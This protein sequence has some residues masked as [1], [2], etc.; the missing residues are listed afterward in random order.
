MVIVNH[1][2]AILSEANS[3]NILKQNLSSIIELEQITNEV[4]FDLLIIKEFELPQK[5]AGVGLARKI[6]MDEA[7]R[8]FSTIHKNGIIACFGADS[9][10]QANYFTEI[11]MAFKEG[12][13]GCNI[14]FEHELEGT[15]HD[16]N[17]AITDYEL[18]LR[19]YNLALNYANIPYAHF[20]VGSSMAVSCE[21]Y[22]KVGGMNKRKAGEDFYFLQKI[23]QLGNFKELTTTT[24]YPSA[25]ISDRVP[26]G[27]GKAISDYLQDL[28][29]DYLT[30]SFLSFE[31]LKDFVKNLRDEDRTKWSTEIK[32]FLSHDF[33]N[34]L[35]RVKN[36]NKGEKKYQH[37]V[38]QLFNAFQVLKYLHYMRD[39][40]ARPVCLDKVV[41][42]LLHELDNDLKVGEMTN[43][44]LLILIREIDRTRKFRTKYIY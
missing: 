32:G 7:L 42:Q 31:I 22:V 21:G 9:T 5:H 15:D 43:K 19:Y 27:T 11:L 44:E 24:V 4:W 40:H 23:I 28:S 41:K 36:N 10:V 18:F 33:S 1:S 16:I 35:D 34:L 37:G 29:V 6:G 12:I 26:F 3:G 38:F 8:R 13:Y 39:K 25:R 2:V 20:T 14:F 17:R 30:Y